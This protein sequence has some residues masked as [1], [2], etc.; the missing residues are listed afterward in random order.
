MSV[1]SLLLCSVIFFDRLGA[2]WLFVSSL[3]VSSSDVLRCC[4]LSDS[5]RILVSLDVFNRYSLYFSIEQFLI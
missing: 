3:E 1:F 5:L 4:Y 2:Y